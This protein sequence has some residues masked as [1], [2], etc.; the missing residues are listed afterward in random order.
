MAPHSTSSPDRA[1][2]LLRDPLD[3]PG[4]LRK[5]ETLESEEGMAGAGRLRVEF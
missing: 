1:P 2:P 3:L 4:A 5:C